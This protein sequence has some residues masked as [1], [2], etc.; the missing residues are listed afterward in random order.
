MHWLSG[1]VGRKVF[2]GVTGGF[3]I[4]FAVLHLLGTLSSLAGPYTVNSYAMKLRGL[5]PLFWAYRVFMVSAL[6]V[7]VVLGVLLTMENWNAKP[8]RYAVKRMLKATFAGETMLWSGLLLLAF[9]AYHLLQFTFHAT[10]DVVAAVDAEG[11]FDVFAMMR[12]SLRIAP[13]ALIYVAATGVLF[14]HLSHGIRSVFQTLGAATDKTLPQF[15]AFG[16]TLSAAF[17]AGYGALPLLI[18][19][20]VGVFGR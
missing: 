9:L 19:A 7:H 14:L 4:L 3:M 8:H 12:N 2:M 5:G 6:A 11:R 17:L 20:G 15:H 10:P 16:M 18:L 13:V 1:T